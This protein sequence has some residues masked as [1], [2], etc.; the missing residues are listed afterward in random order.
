MTKGAQ[1]VIRHSSF[2]IGGWVGPLQTEAQYRL[3]RQAGFNTLL[4]YPWE[5]DNYAE[6]LKLADKV[7]NLA[8][9]LNIDQKFLRYKPEQFVPYERIATFLKEVRDNRRI[10][11]YF[12]YDEPFSDT[13]ADLVSE[14]VKHLR[15]LQSD[16]LGWVN[17][18]HTSEERLVRSVMNKSRPSGIKGVQRP[19]V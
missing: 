14:S 19:R 8:V 12:A 16:R 15:S 17:F 6:T 18:Y 2:V 11:G 5:G 13:E 4:D 7:G 1:F 10:I 9:I 3:Y